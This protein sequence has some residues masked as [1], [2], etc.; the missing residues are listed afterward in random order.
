MLKYFHGPLEQ[1]VALGAP[2]VIFGILFAMPF[3]DRGPD[4]SPRRRFLILA[5]L[6]MLFAGAGL[7]V[8]LAI[9]SDRADAALGKRLAAAEKQRPTLMF[10]TKEAVRLALTGVGVGTACTGCPSLPDLLTRYEQAGGRFLVCPICF[11]ARRLDADQ[12]LG[13]A[14]LGG[15]VPMWRWIGDEGAVTFCY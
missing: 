1:V 14:E 13:N 9:H 4:R 5:P 12:L 6:G 3:I 2:V 8:G 10:L 7:L 15:T 11:E